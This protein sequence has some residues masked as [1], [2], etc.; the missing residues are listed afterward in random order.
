MAFKGDQVDKEEAKVEMGEEREKYHFEDFTE[1]NF[2][3]LLTIAKE[4][5]R[6][7]RYSEAER[8]DSFLLLRHDVDFSPHRALALAEIERQ[9]GVCATFFVQL[10]SF[11]YNVFEKEVMEI[12]KEIKYLGHDLGLHFDADVYG[13]IARE[14]LEAWLEFERKTVE[15]LIAAEIKSFSYHNP[16]PEILRHDDSCYAGMVNAYSAYLREN[17]GYCSDSNGYWRHDRLEDVLRDGEHKRLQVLVH[18]GWWQSE[19]MSPYDRIMRCIE[20]RAEGQRLLY[21]RLLK[22]HGRKNVGK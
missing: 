3:R 5:Y 8:S 13:I 19:P 11:F 17:A 1:D 6:F 2:R 18:P 14:S 9:E 7:I 15:S 22:E 21:D 16:T 10:T 20:G 12:L 4:R